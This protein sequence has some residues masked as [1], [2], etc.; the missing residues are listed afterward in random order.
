MDFIDGLPQSGKIN[1]LWVIVDKRTN[2]AHF[3]PLAHPYTAS[4]VELIYMSSIYRIHGFPASIVSDHD[5]V[6]TSHFWRDLFKYAG[7]ELRMSSANHPQT[8]G[9]TEWVNQCAETQLRCFIHACRAGGA[10]GSLLPNSGTIPLT[11]PVLACHHSRRCSVT[12]C[13]VPALHSWL[14]E[15][16][17]IQDLL[18]QHRNR[19]QQ[20]M[21]TQADKCRSPRTFEVGDSVYLKL[22]PYIQTS[23]A[24]SANHKLAFKYFRPFPIIGKIN[25]AAY[26]LELPE[27]SQVHPVFHVSQLRRCLLP[28]RQFLF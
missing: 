24:R 13:T 22:Q 23:V 21:K 2:F 19:A 9:Q 6:F 27:N 18:Q 8:D 12:G 26:K 15:C 11:S 3:L 17:V 14:N 20:Y 10:I 1:C 25:E 28:G 7:T 16:A 4:K 5:P